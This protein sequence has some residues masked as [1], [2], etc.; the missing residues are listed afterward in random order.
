MQ[1][2]SSAQ[3]G[4]TL[5]ELL[6]VIA[7]IGIL[8]SV[9]L[10]SLNTARKKGND[11]AVK[12]NLATIQTQAQLYYDDNSN[13]FSSTGSQVNETGDCSA[14]AGTMFVDHTIANAIKS[15]NKS[16][17]DSTKTEC[18]VDAGGQ[19]YAMNVQLSTGSYWCV[20]STGVEKIE[21][22]ALG[23]GVNGCL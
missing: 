16:S 19:T 9:V 5:I 14:T 7:I 2:K 12:S 22:A 1:K 18:N 15:A 13:K 17:L 4:F 11:A 23:S 8:S 10:A 3:R 20:D 21:A 6:V